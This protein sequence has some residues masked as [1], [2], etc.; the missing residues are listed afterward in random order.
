M[1]TTPR[2][3]V[4]LDPAVV[5]RLGTLELK[6][7]TIVEGFLS[8]LHRSP[9]KG[10]SVEFAEYRQYIP[11]DDLSTI[12]WKVFARS[13][14]YYVKKFEEETNLD[15]HLMLDVSGS[16]GYG[17]TAMTKFEYGACLAAALAYLM[18]RQRDAVGLTAFDDKIVE[19]LPT[20]SRPGHLRNILLTLDRLKLGRETNVS[21]PLQQIVDSLSK[22]GLVVL[23]SDLFDDADAVIRGLKH[24]Q[25]RGNDVIVFQ[26]LDPDEIDF[27]FERPT[28]FEDLETSEE[29]LAVPG[30]VRDHYVKQMGT[31][32]ER[33]RRELGAAGIDYQLLSTKR[34]LELA[35]M[36]YL[37][38]RSRTL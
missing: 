7:R 31:L 33:Y 22:R 8:G 1:P 18:N 6:A 13:D 25:H 21:K 10:F 30:A 4:F 37:S 16:M 35:L 28:K 20:G 34:P 9:F 23:I 17:S 32:I 24:F 36:S 3:R 15:A 27:P 29:I 26:V 5:A 12:D 38:T 2:D 14:R 19:M 11:G